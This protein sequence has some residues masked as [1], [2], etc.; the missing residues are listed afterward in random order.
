MVRSPR[1]GDTGANGAITGLT[2]VVRNITRAK[3]SEAALR[4]NEQRFRLL[5]EGTEDFV[6]LFDADW[7]RVFNSPAYCRRTGWT[8]EDLEASDFTTRVHPDD[9]ATVEQARVKVA[10]GQAVTYEHRCRCQ[11]GSW[12]WLE[13]HIKQLPSPEGR[14]QYFS[15]SHDITERKRLTESE[16]R[17]QTLTKAIIETVP[18]TFFVLDAAGRIVRWN[19]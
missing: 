13:T 3:E 4:E 16:Q 7:Q 9:L 15:T 11:D 2:C 1:D 12:I 19:A 18:G 8:P 5:A 6:T 14:M 17:E 10:A